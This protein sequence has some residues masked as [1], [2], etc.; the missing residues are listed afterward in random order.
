MLVFSPLSLQPF[1]LVP[2]EMRQLSTR[3]VVMTALPL[4]CITCSGGKSTKGSQSP[5]ITSFQN[6]YG[7]GNRGPRQITGSCSFSSKI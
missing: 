3:S 7:I 6:C 2:A 4:G 5:Q 1:Q